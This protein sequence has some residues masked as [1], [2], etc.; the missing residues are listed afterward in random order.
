MRQ[1]LEAAHRGFGESCVIGVAEAGKEIATRSFQLVTG[2]RWLGTAFGGWKSS[3]DVPKL[4]N[5]TVTGEWPSKHMS[6]TSS[7]DS[8]QSISAL[9]SSTRATV[10]ELSSRYLTLLRSKHPKSGWLA[11]QSCK[12]V[13]T[14]LLSTTA[15]LLMAS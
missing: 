13:C 12:T 1:A 7:R 6:L 15:T 9:K 3:E 2:R 8:K 5:K 10:S 11:A 4:V 14:K